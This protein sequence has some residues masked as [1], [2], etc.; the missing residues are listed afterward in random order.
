M[1]VPEFLAATFLGSLV[2]SGLLI[3]LGNIVGDQQ[4]LAVAFLGHYTQTVLVL[5]GTVLP[6]LA[7]LALLR[8]FRRRA[9]PHADRRGVCCAGADS[10]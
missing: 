9:S 5:A 6:A 1:R 4:H 10:A 8:R 3:G 2:W 7:A